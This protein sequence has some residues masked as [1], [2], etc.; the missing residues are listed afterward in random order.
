M[1]QISDDQNQEDQFA[2]L[3]RIA[4]LV[5]KEKLGALDVQERQEL[6]SWLL[7]RNEHTDWKD[8]INDKD[9]YQEISRLYAVAE[10]GM[11][12]A[13]S[14]FNKKYFNK[15]PDIND[16][17][18]DIV[19]PGRRI[20]YRWIAAATI[21]PLMLVALW[22]LNRKETTKEITG[23][24][25][26]LPAGNKA[27]L[28]L[29]NGQRITLDSGTSGNVIQGADIQVNYK[30]GQVAYQD[31]TGTEKE[32]SWNTLS[33][34]KGGMFHLLLPDGTSVW[35]NAV[36]SIRYP[37]AFVG[38]ERHVELQ[39]Q[40]YF[41]VAAGKEKPFTVAVNGMTVTALGT[42]FDIMA[43]SDESSSRATLVE[44]AVM[45]EKGKAVEQLQP[46]EQAV[47]TAAGDLAVNRLANVESVVA[48]KLGFFQFSHT[49]IQTLMREVAR[50]YDVDIVFQRK[51]IYSKYGGRISRK[52]DLA[53]L[54]SLLEGNGVGHFKMEGRRVIVLP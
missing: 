27:M 40:A 19:P 22:L 2:A 51:D 4:A 20:P 6:E 48:W 52:L 36:S 45:V 46:G 37:A 30:D 24:A 32:L 16:A 26:I 1:L 11:E 31:G 5:A 44:G 54:L 23:Q 21:I 14:A 39:G 53:A 3:A 29:A 7:E 50:W 38:K 18:A 42:A 15:L 43:Y 33:T 13:R 49:D 9:F 35:L 34:G 8:K 28:T 12:A 25:L 47:L 10:S 41:E 17:T